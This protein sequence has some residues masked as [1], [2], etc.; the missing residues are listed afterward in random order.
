MSVQFKNHFECLKTI[1]IKICYICN[2]S[3]GY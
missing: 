2:L 3:I 1:W